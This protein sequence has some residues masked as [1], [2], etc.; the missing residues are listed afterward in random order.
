MFKS[1]RGS[2]TT[3][4]ILYCRRNTLFEEKKENT[5]VKTSF[6]EKKEIRRKYTVR[7]LYH[8]SLVEKKSIQ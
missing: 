4:P 6:E 2:K 7:V 3:A 8:I 5:R 1:S